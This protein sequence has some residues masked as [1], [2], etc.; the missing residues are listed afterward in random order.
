MVVIIMIAMW[1][2]SNIAVAGKIYAKAWVAEF[3]LQDA[4]QKTLNGEQQVRPWPWADTWP[5]AELIVPR[6]D[7]RQIVLSGDSGRVLAFSSGYTEASALPGNQGKTLISGHRDTHFVFLKDLVIGDRIELKTAE[8]NQY[9]YQV[10]EQMVV[11]QRHFR[12]E[13]ASELMLNHK[14]E[15]KISN[16][17][18]VLATCFPFG[19]LQPGGN[20]RYLVVANKIGS[21]RIEL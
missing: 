4:W 2:I 8:G 12:L 18:L 14:A 16:N 13:K 1:G 6:L 19:A 17:I 7:I 9:L 5:I 20:E 3:L 15:G 10:N 21:I 11:D